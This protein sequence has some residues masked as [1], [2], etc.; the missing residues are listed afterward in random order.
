MQ[1][2]QQVLGHLTP[3]LEDP[4]LAGARKSSI[5]RNEVAHTPATDAPAPTVTSKFTSKSTPTTSTNPQDDYFSEPLNKDVRLLRS[6]LIKVIGEHESNNIAGQVQQLIDLSSKYRESHTEKDFLALQQAVHSLCFTSPS[7]NPSNTLQNYSSS[8]CV[9]KPSALQ[10]ARAFHELLNIANLAESHHRIRRWKRFQRGEGQ[11]LSQEQ[12]PAVAFQQLI[13][14]AHISP[15]DLTTAMASQRIDFVLT[16]HP[17][18]ATRRTLLTKYASIAFILSQMERTDL[19]PT[20]AKHLEEELDRVLLACWR[21]NTVRRIR[22]LPMTEARAGA[23]VIE[24]VIWYALPRHLRNV[25]DA[26]IA[27]KAAP[28]PPNYSPIKFSSWM[29][30]DR[31]GNPNVTAEVT[32]EVIWFN[33]W[34]AAD[35]F[36]RACNNLMWLLSM[37]NATEAL[38]ELARTCLK[39]K[40][41]LRKFSENS[42]TG[43][44]TTR[45]LLHV[46]VAPDEPYRIVL[47][48]VRESLYITRK[49][50]ELQFNGDVHGAQDWYSKYSSRIITRKSRLMKPLKACYDSLCA[51]GDSLIAGGELI[52]VMR[53]LDAFGVSLYKLDIRQ[54]SDRHLQCIDAI[55]KF[56][57]LSPSYAEWDE[58]TKQNWLVKELDSARPLIRWPLFFACP[59]A[60]AEVKEVLNTFKMIFEVGQ[61]CFGG[62]VISMARRP[63]DVLAVLLLQ[64]EAGVTYPLRVVPLFEMQIDLA[65]AGSTI[66]RLFS[67]PSYLNRIDRRQEVMLGYSDSSKDAGRMTSVWEL[68]KA[69]EALVEVARA[70]SVELTIFHGRGGSVGRGGG[71]QHLAILSQPPHSIAN[72]LRVTIQGESIEQHFGLIK[73]AQT[74][75]GRYTSATIL[76]TL[77]KHEQIRPEWIDAMNTISKVSSDHYRSIVFKTPSFVRYFQHATPVLEISELKL[78]SRPARRKAG[79]GVE[80]L[81]AIPWIFAWTQTRFH[82]PV[83]LGLGPALKHMIDIGKENV[84]KEMLQ[85]WPFFQS[86]INL[87]EM[88]LVKAD[89][90]IF[91]FYDHLLVPPELL[92]LGEMLRAD[93]KSTISYLLRCTGQKRLLDTTNSDRLIMRAVNSRHPYIDPLN[94]LQAELLKVIRDQEDQ[95]EKLEESD[96]GTGD[97]EGEKPKVNEFGDQEMEDLLRDTLGVSIQAIAAGMQNTG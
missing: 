60:T 32:R 79:G 19:S 45:E 16:A 17:T 85:K 3:F 52:D 47:S 14:D 21:S 33:R 13:Q 82:L 86:T 28:L 73:T 1:R 46:S 40:S 70:F 87:I 68:Y 51:C 22:P 71:P 97:E 80:T 20:A 61:E 64:K 2:Y 81:R 48:Y 57:G 7:G 18:Q 30:G 41:V 5:E 8:P 96:P 84:V 26:L 74:T 66:R 15:E 95:K 31:D 27:N 59:Y 9:L 43:T 77:R 56:Q 53:R 35:L 39:N 38:W 24:D 91:A 90:N 76:A 55:T 65:S 36:Y 25:D 49:Y 12:Q 92:G 34:R 10:I 93:L 94:L 42:R 50:C 23:A 58:E 62:Y 75:F 63:S 54:E 72:R 88:V 69:Q 89:E 6:R 67:I 4:R 11:V 37:T 29:G 44:T 83:W 78:G